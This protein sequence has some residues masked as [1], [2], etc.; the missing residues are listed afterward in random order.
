MDESI[1]VELRDMEARI[2]ADIAG[3]HARHDRTDHRVSALEAKAAAMDVKIE[4]V[5]QVEQAVGGM[6]GLVDR[7]SRI[8]TRVAIYCAGISGGVWWLLEKVW[9]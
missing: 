2:R 1:R 7:V 3:L 6:A 5:E 8:E 4:Q 9:K